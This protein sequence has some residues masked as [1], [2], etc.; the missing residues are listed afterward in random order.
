MADTQQAVGA[1]SAHRPN[2]KSIAIVS[3]K[4]GS[5]K[6]LIASALML[7]ANQNIVPVTIIDG[8]VGT[9]GL[10]YYLAPNYVGGVGTGLADLVVEM[11]VR[12]LN[13]DDSELLTA[14]KSVAGLKY[15]RCL[16]IGDHRLLMDA[17]GSG[18]DNNLRFAFPKYAPTIIEYVAK[19]TDDNI[20]I[21]CRGGIDAD[22]LS[23]C[24]VVDDIIIV[25]ETDATSVQA[26]YHLVSVLRD[27]KL[28]RKIKGFIVNKV[29]DDPTL[30]SSTTAN[31]FGIRYLGAVPFDLETTKRFIVGRLPTLESPLVTNVHNIIAKIYP[32][33]VGQ[34][35]F[36]EWTPE[37][38]RRLTLRDPMSV[39]GGVVLLAIQI[40]LLSLVVLNSLPSFAKYNTMQK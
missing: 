23:L 39:Y 34:P 7:A 6:T 4:G 10:S 28:H 16:T 29:F 1:T 31:F 40:V 24:E 20:I 2:R 3:G 35:R 38:Y 36:R 14:I 32:E 25:V 15:S 13:P 21:D 30:F 33:L 8:D 22:S 37:E 17:S 26:S 9:G 27:R 18:S 5:G 12:A 11:A 19:N